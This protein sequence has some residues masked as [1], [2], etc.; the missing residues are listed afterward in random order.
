[1]YKVKGFHLIGISHQKLLLIQ[2]KYKL[3]TL[4]VGYQGSPSTRP[5]TLHSWEETDARDL[6]HGQSETLHSREETDARDLG[7]GQSET[8]HSQEETDARDLGHGQSE[9]LHS[10]EETDGKNLG[11]GQSETLHSREET[12]GRGQE[13]PWSQREQQTWRQR[14]GPVGAGF[15]P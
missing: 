12:D 11:H 4:C 5:E 2:Q 13:P 1:M 9:T 8:L 3:C 15:P 7:H 14:L 6:G 10:R